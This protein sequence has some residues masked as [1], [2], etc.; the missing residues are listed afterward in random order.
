ML[1]VVEQ[2]AGRWGLFTATETA[3]AESEQVSTGNDQADGAY[4]DGNLSGDAQ[5]PVDL[6]AYDLPSVTV[7]HDS[8]NSL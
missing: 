1:S 8:L 3:A 5:S 4:D 7:S 2:R 6:T